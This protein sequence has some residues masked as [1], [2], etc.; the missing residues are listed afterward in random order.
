MSESRLIGFKDASSWERRGDRIVGRARDKSYKE[1]LR[2]GIPIE[3]FIDESRNQA[4]TSL[5]VWAQYWNSKPHILIRPRPDFFEP[6]PSY[7][8]KKY[9]KTHN[10]CNC[11]LCSVYTDMQIDI[12]T[13]TDSDYSSMSVSSHHSSI[14]VETDYGD[15]LDLYPKLRN[16]RGSPRKS[17]SKKRTYTPK[18]QKNARILN[19]GKVRID[20]ENLETVKYEQ[21]WQDNLDNVISEIFYKLRY[22]PVKSAK[23]YSNQDATKIVQRFA[24]YVDSAIHPTAKKIIREWELRC[25]TLCSEYKELP[26][27]YTP[28]YFNMSDWTEYGMYDDNYKDFVVLT[29]RLFI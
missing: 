6:D 27:I 28:R 2:S 11:M 18:I 5:S 17:R 12:D 24:T 3:Y 14:N 13:D 8:K 23:R 26:V 16:H 15:S 10:A 25:K 22:P 19:R 9:T 21:E 20:S 29:F 7:L 4:S 1:I